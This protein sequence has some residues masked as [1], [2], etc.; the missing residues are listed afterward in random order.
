MLFTPHSS[1]ASWLMPRHPWG[2]PFVVRG[3]RF[4][5]GGFTLLE[6]LTV[7]A[8]IAVM[9]AAASA[10]LGGAGRGTGVSGAVVAASGLVEAARTE[11]V[12][13]GR[14]A[15]LA[16]DIDPSSQYY[17]RRWAVLTADGA[18]R[19][20]MRN[21]PVIFPE[22]TY[23][24]EKYS[25]GYSNAQVEFQGGVQDGTTGTRSGVFEF[26]R[27]GR[28]VGG[29]QVSRI[30]CVSGVMSDGTEPRTLEV[31]PSLEGGRDGFILR[32]A[33]G[34]TFFESPAQIQPLP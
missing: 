20:E 14:G 3:W 15:R 5:A 27:A 16:V 22:E 2:L 4:A 11:A 1:S 24:F 34:V 32:R 33:G 26:D 23:F 25:S 28:L 21:K 13:K 29:A 18:G 12:L 10:L 30:I 9:M 19:W 17:L 31:P 6:M 8:I 7:I